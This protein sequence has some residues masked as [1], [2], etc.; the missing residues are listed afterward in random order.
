MGVLEMDDVVSLSPR[1][2]EIKVNVQLRNLTGFIWYKLIG[3][4]LRQYVE[5]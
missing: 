4:N 3:T 2:F 5:F 1:H